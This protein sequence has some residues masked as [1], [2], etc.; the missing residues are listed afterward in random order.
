MGENIFKPFHRKP[1]FQ[2]ERAMCVGTAIK[3]VL[4]NQFPKSTLPLKEINRL[5]KYEGKYQT[6]VAID[7]LRELLS[8]PLKKININFHFKE[9]ATRKDLFN[10]LEQGCYPIVAFH[11]RDYN[12]WQSNE[13]TEVIG[14]DE[15]TLH[16]LVVV[17][18]DE[19]KQIIKL[20]NTIHNKYKDYSNLNE[21]YEE[22]SFVRFNQCWVHSELIYPCFWFSSNQK[23][24]QPSGSKKGTLK[25]Y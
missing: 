10:L 4:D 1:I 22:I 17:G 18:V 5:C 24:K 23:V 15:P 21:M 6:G 13:E 14:D 8:E 3:N 2:H 9:N 25:D 16:V 20:F 7:G 12:E 11:L 19:E